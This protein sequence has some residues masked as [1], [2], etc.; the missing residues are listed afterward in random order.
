MSRTYKPAALVNANVGT[1]RIQFSDT[2]NARLT[3]P[4]GRTIPITR[5]RF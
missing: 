1:V 4:D 3:L 2:Q 5:F